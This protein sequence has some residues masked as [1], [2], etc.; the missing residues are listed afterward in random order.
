V[1]QRERVALREVVDHADDRGFLPDPQM[2]LTGDKA[3]MPQRAELH[4]QLADPRHLQEQPG[5]R[6]DRGTSIGKR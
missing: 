4:L 6:R 3:L 1:V 2:Q 5:H